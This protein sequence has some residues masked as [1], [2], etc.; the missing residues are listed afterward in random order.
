VRGML[1]VGE[2]GSIPAMR[3]KPISAF[4]SPFTVGGSTFSHSGGRLLR[5]RRAVRHLA[6]TYEAKTKSKVSWLTFPVR[7]T[8]G[9]CRMYSASRRTA[10]VPLQLLP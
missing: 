4:T 5:V 8:A 7:S 2:A 6:P 1:P 9:V 10:P 3:L